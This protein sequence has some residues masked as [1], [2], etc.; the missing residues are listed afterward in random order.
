RASVALLSVAVAS[1]AE[2]LVTPIRVGRIDAPLRLTVWAQQDYS[3]LASRAA[4][5]RVFTDIFTEWAQARPD[6]RLDL[7][8]MPA[9]ELQKAKL[10]MAAASGRLPDVASVDSF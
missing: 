3:H 9:L 4:S 5:K 8:V 10:M 7:S 6:V 1:T 2:D